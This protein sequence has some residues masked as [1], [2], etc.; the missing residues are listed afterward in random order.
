[1]YCIIYLYSTSHSAHES[2]A[3]PVQETQRK[4]S[5]LEKTCFSHR[6]PRSWDKEIVP[7]VNWA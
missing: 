7:P 5:S 1:M 6:S 2:E 4:E 3:L